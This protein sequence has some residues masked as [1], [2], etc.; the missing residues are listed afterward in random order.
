VHDESLV[1]TRHHSILSAIE[2]FEF[3][4][5]KH[6]P[7]TKRKKKAKAIKNRGEGDQGGQKGGIRP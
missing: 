4:R 6:S 7:N 3:K 5:T 2:E 1:A